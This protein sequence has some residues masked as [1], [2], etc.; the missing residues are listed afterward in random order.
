[1][2]LETQHE[3]G[4]NGI[5]ATLAF[6]QLC[7]FDARV[8]TNRFAGNVLK[9]TDI[10]L[11]IT[12]R[13]FCIRKFTSQLSVLRNLLVRT[14]IFVIQPSTLCKLEEFFAFLWRKGYCM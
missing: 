8:S 14:L 11:G 10:K 1:M 9:S 2:I 4:T 13:I 7:E 5:R 12:N 6:A 3:Y